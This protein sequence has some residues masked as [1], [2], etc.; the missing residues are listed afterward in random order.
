LQ[1]AN[2]GSP[3]TWRVDDF[4]HTFFTTTLAEEDASGR[5]MSEHVAANW[6]APVH[7][8][9]ECTGSWVRLDLVDD[10]DSDVE[11][12]GHLSELAE[13]LA[14]LTLALVQLAAT[15]VV[16]AEVRHDAVDDEET[17]LS[18]SERLS[19]TAQLLV[20]VLAVLRAGIEDILVG[21]F[22]VD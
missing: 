6:L 9:K 7:T 8:R 11:L 5:C 20:L 17:E 10:Q 18:R 19:Q 12:F 15:M 2:Q 13:M 4:S 3:H 1:S 22:G 14:E 21:S 16:I